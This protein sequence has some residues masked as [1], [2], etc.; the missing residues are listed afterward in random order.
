MKK[1]A[2][3]SNFLR[4]VHPVRILL[5][6]LSLL[7]SG[8]AWGQSGSPVVYVSGTGGF[9]LSVNTS[10]GAVTTLV[11]NSN[12]AYEGLVVGPDNA[13][14]DNTSTTNHP[15]LLYACDPTHNTIIRFD[16]NNTAAGI[17]TVYAGNGGLQQPQCGRFT[18]AGD[19]IV[20]SK[21]AGSGIWDIAG[22]ANIALGAGGFPTPTQDPPNGAFS[23]TQVSQGIA[24]KNIGDLLIVDS[25]NKEIIR[26]PYTTS[27]PFSGKLSCF[28]GPA[29]P[30]TNITLL[31]PGPF[32]I[33]RKSAGDLYL[34]NQTKTT[35]NIVH[36]NSQMKSVSTCVT[37]S[38]TTVPFFMQMSA[39]DTLYVAT[40]SSSSGAVFSVNTGTCVATQISTLVKLPPLIGVA[41]PPTTVSQTQSFSGTQTFNFGFAA[42]QITS[43]SPGCTLTVQAFPTNL[44]VVQSLIMGDPTDFPFGGTPA[45]NLG[46]DG[47]EIAF[48]VNSASNTCTPQFSDGT[49]IPLQGAQVD[50]SLVANPRL[51][52]CD[53]S[54]SNCS[55]NPLFGDYPLGGLLP[56]DGTYG[57]K[58]T[59]CSTHYLANA[60]L[61]KTEPGTFCG[62]QSPFTVPNVPPPGISGVFSSGQTVSVKF[63]LASATGDCKNGPFITD[64]VALLSVAQILDANGNPVFN[65]VVIGAS[66][67]STPIQPIFKNDPTNK[68]YQFSLSLAGYAP[69]IYS[70]TL[71][72]LSSNTAFQVIEFQVL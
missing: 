61:S 4:G 5:F 22:V 1:I 25:A 53:D 49:F 69:G 56:S 30:C 19:L 62:L 13:A 55:V 68:Q 45:V 38:N 37:F 39:D 47:F 42:Y 70:L 9:I 54:N 52:R 24:Q 27:P 48:D 2:H 65:A 23:P 71:T 35:K 44:A 28:I 32:G 21:V 57:S 66:G 72:F 67:N 64:A 12:A 18:N 36:F 16:P 40:S 29:S 31:L 8:Y 63:K 34:S 51:I 14:S 11:S 59:C 41:L 7:F 58:G 3:G 6:S 17:E 46:W 15:F 33:A 60:N 50:N 20:T 26:S 10:S 43:P